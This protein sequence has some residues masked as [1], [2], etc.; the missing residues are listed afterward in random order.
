MWTSEGWGRNFEDAVKWKVGEGR[1]I[2]FWEDSWLNYGALKRDFSRQKLQRW[3]SL[4][5]G[6]MRYGSGRLNGEG[7]Y[8]SGRRL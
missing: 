1:D 8:S 5:F 6:L 4:G 7:H 2:T 3:N